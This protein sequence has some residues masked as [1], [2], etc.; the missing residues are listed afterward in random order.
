MTWGVIR[1]AIFS[2]AFGA[3]FLFSSSLG[4]HNQWN[5]SAQPASQS[6]EVKCTGSRF[7]LVENGERELTP[8]YNQAF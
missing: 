7:V 4:S 1:I 3:G 2:A 8:G 5:R 6:R